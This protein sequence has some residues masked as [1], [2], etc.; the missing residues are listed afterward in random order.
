MR[1]ELASG[2]MTFAGIGNI[3]ACILDGDQRR[4]MVSHN[5]ILG[6]NVS[7]S[8]EFEYQWPARARLIAHSDGLQ[9]QW[10]L[11]GYPGINEHHPAIIA[12]LLFR[13]YSRGRDDVTVLVA[14]S[15][16][17]GSRP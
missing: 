3:A 9:T 8:Q 15:R 1:H 10:S 4:A 17:A 12:A 5:G 16:A 2:R 13:D 11:D 6:H 7:R 14:R